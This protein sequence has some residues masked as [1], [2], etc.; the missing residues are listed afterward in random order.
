MLNQIFKFAGKVGVDDWVVKLFFLFVATD[1][2]FIIIHVIYAHTDLIPYNA[3]SLATDRGYSEL[4]QY[5]KEYWSAL[6][7]GLLALQ[8]RSPLYLSWSLLLFYLLL[9]DSLQIHEKLGGFIS[10]QLSFSSMFNLRAKDF[11][12]LT[13]SIVVFLLFLCAIYI[14][15]SWSDHLSRQRSKHLIRLLF[16]LA[17]FGVVVNMLHIAFKTSHLLDTLFTVIE[18]GGEMLIMSLITCYILSWFVRLKKIVT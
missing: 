1:M 10:N 9:D 17:F 13:V 8:F 15:Y 3:F 12:E 14:S 16:I 4:F 6:F 11:G 2:T 18:D 7:S 5:I